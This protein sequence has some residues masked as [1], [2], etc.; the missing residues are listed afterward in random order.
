MG[1][2]DFAIDNKIGHS[3]Q[4]FAVRAPILCL[5]VNMIQTSINKKKVYY[6]PI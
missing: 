6:I 5:H 3:D 4:W 2:I 1:K